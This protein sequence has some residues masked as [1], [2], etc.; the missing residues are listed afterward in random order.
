MK[1]NKK[2]TE[3]SGLFGQIVPG[4]R[5]RIYYPRKVIWKKWPEIVGEAVAKVS[6]PLYFR[7]INGLVVGVKDNLWMQQL[8]YER[9]MI[10]K[11]IN[12]LLPEHSKL[13]EI[14]FKIEDISFLQIKDNKS[15]KKD[16]PRLLTATFNKYEIESLNKIKDQELKASFQRLLKN[17]KEKGPENY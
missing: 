14:Y 5:W 7:D 8:S 17:I 15:K 11:K 12:E 16:K 4:K 2:P 3:L 10:L 13:K 6:W 1:E 9:V